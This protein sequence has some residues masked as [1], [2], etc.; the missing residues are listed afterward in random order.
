MKIDISNFID[1]KKL[2]DILDE[3]Q[4]KKI[5][6]FGAGTATY[7][8][9]QLLPDSVKI[10]YYLDSNSRLWGVNSQGYLIK[11]PKDIVLEEKGEYVVLIISQHALSMKKQLESY[12]LLEGADFFD[13]YTEF[14]KLF[15][16]QKIIFQADKVIEIINKTPTDA[17]DSVY[18]QTKKIGVVAA[19]SYMGTPMIHDIG[20]F[21]LL[22]YNG[23]PAELIMDNTYTC[24]NFT[25]Y[26][27]ASDDIKIV[28]DEVIKCI[29]KRFP[30]LAIKHIKEVKNG[31][32]T[33]SD[34]K[35]IRQLSRISTIWQKSRQNE[36]SMN[37][38]ENV[39]EEKLY[40]VFKSN[41]I[42]I[43]S[44]FEEN[45]YN[46]I[47]VSTAL[48]YHR[49]LYMWIGETKKMRVA[50]YDGANNDGKTSWATNYPNGHHYD[51]PKL[52]LE[53]SF[54][55]LEKVQIIEKAKNHFLERRYAISNGE[56]YNYQLVKDGEG[57]TL[58]KW[59]DV[60]IPL[61]V[62]WDAAAIGI[63]Q[64]FE[65]EQEWLI[66][67][68]NFLLKST[69]ASIMVREHPVQMQ[70]D[71]YNNSDYN[72]II[73][74]EFGQNDRLKVV[75]YN[76]KINTYEIIDHCKLILPLSS[77]IGVEAAFMGKQVIVHSKCYYSKLHFVKAAKTKDEYFALIKMALDDKFKADQKEIDEAYMSYY[78]LMNSRI[79]TFFSEANPEWLFHSLEDLSCDESVKAILNAI[80]NDIPI[81]YYNAILDLQNTY[82]KWEE[83]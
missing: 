59:Y 52:I 20:I 74:K 78:L 44:F 14:E 79:E 32:L 62:M 42:N 9:Q 54:T 51:I 58:Q 7:F 12:G 55:E 49:G 40:T 65:T 31:Q 68:I 63:N 25:M 23:Y 22:N 80:V 72:E 67:T 16:M 35:K 27:G 61:N 28:T 81:P 19:C 13:L 60:L 47:T 57:E 83:R 1:K 76:D 66:D 36:R 6:C 26:E 21:L 77:T 39:L 69:S 48:H 10:E 24:E 45:N 2:I 37:F 38:D 17:F 43:K 50:N 8:M 11:N 33:D 56:R 29:K 71:K 75:K 70:L 18:K 4:G 73:N 64:V 15:R 82:D 30:Q 5:I 34:M 41:L 3:N 53:G 46:T